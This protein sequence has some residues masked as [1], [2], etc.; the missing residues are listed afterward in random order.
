VDVVG[1]TFHSIQSFKSDTNFLSETQIESNFSRFSV[2]G[3][4][5]EWENGKGGVLFIPTDGK[6]FP[7]PST[8]RLA[9]EN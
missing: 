2:C 4:R 8:L 6:Y 7:S 3:E 5:V 1:E 9:F